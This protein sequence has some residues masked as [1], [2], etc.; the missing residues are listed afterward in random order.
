MDKIP[1]INPALI[2][3]GAAKADNTQVVLKAEVVS[4]SPIPLDTAT[5]RS[6]NRQ[7]TDASQIKE[8]SKEQA[9]NNTKA[10]AGK[11]LEQKQSPKQET[12]PEASTNQTQTQPSRYKIVLQIGQQKL[13]TISPENLKPGSQI[14]IKVLPGPELKIINADKPII[15]QISNGAPTTQKALVQQLLLDRIPRTQQQDFSGIIK[16]LNQIIT[17][18]VATSPID[19][20]ATI[21]DSNNTQARSTASSI[22]TNNPASPSSLTGSQ[23]YQ[24]LQTQSTIHSSTKHSST[25]NNPLPPASGSTPTT[26]H[27]PLQ[28]VKSWLEK[29]PQSQDITTSTG[30]RNALGNTGIQ[31]ESQLTQLAKQSLSL[32]PQSANSI[33]QQLKNLHQSLSPQTNTSTQINTNDK[34]QPNS[35]SSAIPVKFDLSH[36]VKKTAKILSNNS[37]QVLASLSNKN[38]PSLKQT[39]PSVTANTAP[40]ITTNLPT[41]TLNWQNP[42]LNNQ[43]YASLESLLQDPLLKTPSSNN[44]LALSQIL[45]LGKQSGLNDVQLNIPLN[46]PDR[47][48][49]DGVLLRT[50]QNLLGHIEREQVQQMQQAEGNQGSNA[51]LQTAA[52][53]QWLPLIIHHQQQL[54]LIEF[55]IDKEEKLNTAGEKKNHWFINLHFDLPHM[56]PMGIEIAMMDN[57]CSTTFWSESSSVLS[58]ISH[59]IQP[60]RQRLNEQGIIVNDIQSRHGLLEKRKHNIQQRLVDI[61]T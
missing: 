4:S 10:G 60:L 17:G 11:D 27:E 44:K 34:S 29:L 3:A 9:E 13:E 26:M 50:L 31:S 12:K 38:L 21:Q 35:T 39:G 32:K 40:S 33:F 61:S 55:F 7:Q 20:P 47:A 15:D 54:Q 49:N 24:K 22:L 14:E 8:P 2:R 42:L 48:G 19:K 5:A 41:N 37:Q 59:H 51:N 6:D 43:Q 16:Q 45:G 30:L 56:G 18:K 57:E 25:N 1:L 28:Q 52:N 36:L 58:Q 46:W 23:L 53:Q